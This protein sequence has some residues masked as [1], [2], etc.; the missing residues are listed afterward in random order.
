MPKYLAHIGSISHGTMRTEDLLPLFARVLGTFARK[1]RLSGL[2][3]SLLRDA[4]RIQRSGEW[5]SGD[6]IHVLDELFEA[7]DDYAPMYCHFGAP[8]GDGSDYGFWPLDIED[9]QR[10]VA[11]NHGIVVSDLSEVP[12]RFSGEILLI[13]D[14]GS[15]SLYILARKKLKLIWSIV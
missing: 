3:R 6:A 15:A 5:S 13:N 4:R 8:E 10:L 2:Y 12:P 9:I 11:E 7:L 1:N 14:H